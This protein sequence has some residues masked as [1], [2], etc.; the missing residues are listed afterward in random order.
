[1]PRKATGLTAAKVKSAPSGRYGDGGGLYLLV[2]GNAEARSAFWMFRYVRAGR[3]REMGLGPAT[4]RDAVTLATARDKASDM[5]RMHTA[6]IDPLDERNAEAARQKAMAQQ[7]EVQALSFKATAELYMAAHEAGWRNEKHK[8]QW[9]A[10]LTAYTFP[11]FGDLPV[12][13]VAI[14]DVMSALEP[15]WTAKPETASRVRGRIEAVLDYATARG[16]RTGENPARW[17][18]HLSNL[19]PS[20]AKVARVEHH[21]ALP[22]P[23]IGAFMKTL[24]PREAASVS[25]MALRFTILTAARSGEVLGARW[26][27]IDM[28]ARIWTVPGKRMKAGREHRVP[29][30]VEALGVLKAAIQLRADDSDAGFVFP[31]QRP[32]NGLSSMALAMTLRRM[33]RPDLTVHG[34]RSAFRDWASETTSFDGATAEAALAHVVRDKVEAAYRRGD[35]FEKRRRLM[36]AWATF[37]AK[38]PAGVSEATPLRQTARVRG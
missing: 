23:Q 32:K 31:G 16:W 1:M 26:S 21:S 4:G 10:T 3:M 13:S 7:A 27:E 2:R 35:L 11:H 36:D 12:V 18:G 38:P 24:A 9:K 19:L 6:G 29:L 17:R 33:G 37:C 30:S 22:W 34:F 25:A 15:I 28:V 5:R 20:R 14:G 8:A